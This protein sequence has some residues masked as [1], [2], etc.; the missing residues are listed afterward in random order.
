MVLWEDGGPKTSKTVD[1]IGGV[2]EGTDRG[3]ECHESQSLDGGGS[4]R[5]GSTVRGGVGLIIAVPS[6]TKETSNTVL[7]GKL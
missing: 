2:K 6:D 3:A 7:D 1:L 4:D 5:T